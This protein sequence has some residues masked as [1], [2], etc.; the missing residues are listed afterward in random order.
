MFNVLVHVLDS[1][2][3]KNRLKNRINQVNEENW[4]FIFGQHCL[5]GNS[6]TKI[7]QW[8]RKT[9]NEADANMVQTEE[10]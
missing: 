8:K 9:E 5:Q 3:V 7:K 1:Q 2:K 4:D 6:E 10:K